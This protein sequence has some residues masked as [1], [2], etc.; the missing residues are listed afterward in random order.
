MARDL[1]QMEF[2]RKNG[3]QILSIKAHKSVAELFTSDDTEIS[4]KYILLNG[5]KV[6]YYTM[7]D[8]LRNYVEGYNRTAEYLSNGNRDMVALR[9]FG[10]NLVAQSNG[11]ESYSN[12]SIL[13]AVRLEEGVE[14]VVDG[15][16][17]DNEVEQWMSTLSRFVKFLYK[18]FIDEQSIKAS[19]VIT[20]E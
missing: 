3:K 7:T 19:L 9:E 8:R 18:N 13:R 20:K 2:S 14:L 5:K 17:L 6:K 4:S 11:G 10:T 1:V 15:L 16:I 12:L